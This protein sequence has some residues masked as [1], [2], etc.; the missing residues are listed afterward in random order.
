MTT[1]NTTKPLL[2]LASLFLALA[3]VANAGDIVVTGDRQDPCQAD[4]FCQSGTREDA[5]ALTEQPDFNPFGDPV[6]DGG[7]GTSTG[8]EIVVVADRQKKED[9]NKEGECNE[10]SSNSDFLNN[11][12]TPSNAVTTHGETHAKTGD[13]MKQTNLDRQKKLV[14]DARADG[15]KVCLA[16]EFGRG[17]APSSSQEAMYDYADAN[18]IPAFNMDPSQTAANAGD[19]CNTISYDPVDSGY[20]EQDATN[21]LNAADQMMAGSIAAALGSGVGGS[22]CDKV[23]AIVGDAH[24]SQ[25]ISSDYVGTNPYL[26]MTL[27]DWLN[28]LG[29]DPFVDNRTMFDEEC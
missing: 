15:S 29:I 8:N 3:P 2:I 13:P 14:D 12:G 16:M 4:P 25:T 10:Q 26:R 9:E 5:L 21:C 1:S 23:I 7:G 20:S 19:F 28:A 22:D 6:G 18:G 17:V 27:V 11:G 24:T